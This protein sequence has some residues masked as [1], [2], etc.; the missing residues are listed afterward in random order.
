MLL[1]TDGATT[2]WDRASYLI[3]LGPETLSLLPLATMTFNPK[4]SSSLGLAA[5]LAFWVTKET[6]SQ[7][8]EC[9]GNPAV[10]SPPEGKRGGS[11]VGYGCFQKHTLL[12]LH[13]PRHS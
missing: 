9:Q 13:Q 12:I 2:V 3:L 10:T 5:G 1:G 6:S 7:E 4:R 11:T 8:Q